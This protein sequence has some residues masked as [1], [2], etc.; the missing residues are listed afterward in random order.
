MNY[1][2]KQDT[3]INQK[4]FKIQKYSHHSFCLSFD[5]PRQPTLIFRKCFE[6]CSKE[7]FFG[8]EE[9]PSYR[10]VFAI[11]N[12][13]QSP[14]PLEEK[15]MST[16]KMTAITM[17]MLGCIYGISIM[18]QVSHLA[19]V[20]YASSN[21]PIGT[22]IKVP[23]VIQSFLIYSMKGHQSHSIP[24]QPCSQ[25]GLF[26]PMCPHRTSYNP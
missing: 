7:K 17:M 18:H 5:T 1:K 23:M 14:L 6:F 13:R 4:D 25:F 26:S 8:G 16:A 12:S 21:C 10:M 2:T 15:P 11:I 3:G 19:Y 22:I 9:I 24:P 20:I